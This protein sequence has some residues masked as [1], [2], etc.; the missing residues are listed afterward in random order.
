VLGATAPQADTEEQ[1][2][3]WEQLTKE[4]PD[5]RDAYIKAASLAFMLGKGQ[6]AREFANKALALDPNASLALEILRRLD[7]EEKQ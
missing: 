7:D 6:K 3:Y 2:L 4:K 5:Y 1:F